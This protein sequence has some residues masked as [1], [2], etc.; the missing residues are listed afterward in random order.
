MEM[1]PNELVPELSVRS[2][3]TSLNFYINILGFTIAYQRVNEG[4]AYIVL[5]NVQIMLDEL[6]NG[7]DWKT[8]EL[9]FPLGRGINFQI[10]VETIEP[11]LARLKSF[12]KAVFMDVESKWYRKNNIEI[13]NRQFLVQDPDGY[14]LRLTE[15]LGSRTIVDNNELL[16]INH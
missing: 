2:L 5:N 1:I 12:N 6:D 7:R 16:S 14:L 11:I 10:K 15:D 4:F 9:E 3:S 13:G 8:G